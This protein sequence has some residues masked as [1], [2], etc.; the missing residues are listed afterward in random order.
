MQPSPSLVHVLPFILSYMAQITNP[1]SVVALCNAII[2][3][4]LEKHSDFPES[5]KTSIPEDEASMSDSET[6]TYDA[7]SSSDDEL[8]ELLERV[9]VRKDKLNMKLTALAERVAFWEKRS[10]R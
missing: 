5:D 9:T 4:L 10:N 1:L 6:K 3:Y 8:E 7:E 2:W